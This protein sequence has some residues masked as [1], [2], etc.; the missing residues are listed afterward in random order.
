[1]SR[2]EDY[3]PSPLGYVVDTADVHGV[4]IGEVIISGEDVWHDS[5]DVPVYDLIELNEPDGEVIPVDGSIYPEL[6][7]IVPPVITASNNILLNVNCAGVDSQDWLD[8]TDPANIESYRYTY[9]VGTGYFEQSK[10]NS[11]ATVDSGLQ[12]VD[13]TSLEI[14]Y[15]LTLRSMCSTS[16]TL[17]SEIAFRD[18]EGNNIIMFYKESSGNNTAVSYR[19]GEGSKTLMYSNSQVVEFRLTKGTGNV[20]LEDVHTSFEITLPVDLSLAESVSI[21]ATTY[22]GIATSTSVTASVMSMKLVVSGNLPNLPRIEGSPFPNK[23]VA[24][25]TGGS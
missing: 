16:C 19:V 12:V 10:S 5:K 2:A 18:S 6:A 20:L 9:S 14:V 15:P 13:I 23:V 4:E 25:Y 3:L 7:R 8:F 1:M 11:L 21:D 22:K 24:D 17:Y